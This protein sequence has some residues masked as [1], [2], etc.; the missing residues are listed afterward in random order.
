M[1]LRKI[2]M[3]PESQQD[4]SEVLNKLA[5][6]AGLTEDE[7]ERHSIEALLEPFKFSSQSF[8]ECGQFEG[9]VRSYRGEEMLTCN[10]T[11]EGDKELNRASLERIGQFHRLTTRPC[12]PCMRRHWMAKGVAAADFDGI[13]D[14]RSDLHEDDPAR[15]DF[16]EPG[17]Q[18]VNF[19]RRSWDQAIE[20]PTAL[21]VHYPSRAE[22]TT[23]GVTRA[24]FT[25][26]VP[27]EVELVL[28]SKVTVK[29][30]LVAVVLHHGDGGNHGHY[31]CLVHDAAHG[32]WM[33]V[34]DEVVTDIPRIERELDAHKGS[35]VGAV[36]VQ[37][38]RV[39]T[40]LP[41]SEAVQGGGD[42]AGAHNLPEEAP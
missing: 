10:I 23:T 18:C 7:L 15:V 3:D 37:E 9:E 13:Y 32:K 39:T 42:I 19:H 8:L 17:A 11:G 29:M 30:V 1:L 6:H 27:L 22:W 35:I 14:A 40:K 26:K 4:Y 21:M 38:G 5:T 12:V 31:T 41:K 34:N 16:M 33:H 24:N 2:E 28:V 25:V 36:F 20:A